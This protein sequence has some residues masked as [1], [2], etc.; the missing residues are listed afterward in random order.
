MTASA[1]A[2]AAPV[3]VLAADKGKPIITSIVTLT[4]TSKLVS[5]L[6]QFRLFRDPTYST[7]TST[8]NV[9]LLEMDLHYQMDTIGS[10]GEMDKP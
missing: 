1:P 7:D 4:G 9:Y 5:S 8:A 10:I 6:L 3:P 2:I